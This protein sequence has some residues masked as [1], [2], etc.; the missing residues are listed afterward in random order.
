MSI[1][2]KNDNELEKMRIASHIVAQTHKIVE[3]FIKPGISTKELDDIA[4]SK[5]LS[6]NAIPSF[7]NYNN[8]PASICISI[9]EEV[10]HCIPGSRV[11]KEGDIISVDIGAY[12]DGFHGDAARTHKVGVVD[13]ISKKLIKVTEDSFF[14]GMKYAKAGNF[15]YD[16]SEAI[17]NHC[18]ENGF[19]IVRD[20]VGHGIGKDLHEDPQIPN[21]KPRGK[22]RGC[23]LQK[24]MVLAIEPMVNVGTDDVKVLK[25]NWTVITVDLKRSAHYENTIIIT[26]DEPEILT[27]YK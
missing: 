15:L 16:I 18:N 27:L 6:F 5:I 17:Y 21:Y 12:I 20:Y 9:N 3:A 8:F 26:D 23:R 11:L 25:D 10:I 13:D 4:E 19:S 14:E 7:K 2:I 24:G 1:F 22:G